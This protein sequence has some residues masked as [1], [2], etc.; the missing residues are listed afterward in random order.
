MIK[1]DVSMSPRHHYK[2]NNL[3]LDRFVFRSLGL[4]GWGGGG[5]DY[6]R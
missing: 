3:Y 2:D 5:G 4:E 6:D 1:T